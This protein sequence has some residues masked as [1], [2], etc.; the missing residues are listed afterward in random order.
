M[1]RILTKLAENNIFW[2]A[3]QDTLKDGD[4]EAYSIENENATSLDFSTHNCVKEGISSICVTSVY[5]LNDF[6]KWHYCYSKI[7]FKQI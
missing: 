1:V 6:I 2:T 4:C 3:S 5:L 7:I